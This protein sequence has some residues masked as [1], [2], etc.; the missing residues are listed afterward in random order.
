[1]TL[2]GGHFSSPPRPPSS[3]LPPPSLLLPPSSSSSHQAQC[4]FAFPPPSSGKR[5][6]LLPRVALPVPLLTHVLGCFAIVA[7]L[8]YLSSLGGGRNRFLFLVFAVE[9]IFYFFHWV[10]TRGSDKITEACSECKVD[11]TLNFKRGDD[12]AGR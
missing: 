2:S 9:K 5:S 12:H 3:L 4:R 7:G 1:M 11:Y 8:A 6:G 10:T